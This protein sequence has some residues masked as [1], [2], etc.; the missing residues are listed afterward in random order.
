MTHRPRR[1]VVVTIVG[2]LLA[3]AAPARAAG[4]LRVRT[5]TSSSLIRVEDRVRFTVTVK[6]TGSSRIKRVTVRDFV[7]D[8]LDVL[9]VPIL[10]RV[11]SAGLSSMGEKEEIFWSIER[12]RPQEKVTLSF[13]AVVVRFGDG[14]LDNDVVATGSDGSRKEASSA[15]YL[16]PKPCFT[17]RRA[18]EVT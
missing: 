14:R 10:D 1:L 7:D 4:N 15:I 8:D 3:V 18:A 13:K 5:G 6:N 11:A 12:L 16:V 9:G 17:W 2:A